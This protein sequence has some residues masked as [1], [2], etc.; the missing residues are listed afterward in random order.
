MDSFVECCEIWFELVLGRGVAD[1]MLRPLIRA[2][3]D[4]IN[5]F[6]KIF[7][8]FT[9]NSGTKEVLLW[10][11]AAG[12]C[13][14]KLIYTY[15][16]LMRS[17]W[18]NGMRYYDNDFFFEFFNDF[19]IIVALYLLP[20]IVKM[21]FNVTPV[22]LIWRSIMNLRPQHAGDVIHVYTNNEDAT[23]A[24]L[25]GNDREVSVCDYMKQ[26]ESDSNVIAER[27]YS[28]AGVYLLTGIVIAIL[29]IAV[30]VAYTKE[31]KQEREFTVVILD[32]LPKFGVMFFVEFIAFYFF[33]QHRVLM[34]EFRFYESIKRQRQ[35]NLVIVKLAN[36]NETL[37]NSVSGHI[38]LFDNPDKMGANETTGLNELRKLSNEELGIFHKILDLTQFIKSEEGKNKAGNNMNS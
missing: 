18:D 16:Y 37:L 35:S 4:V 8:F 2:A 10:W 23:T 11:L 5:I 12:A 3:E 14:I 28:R 9:K 19:L 7:N 13:S 31:M 33:K 34:D 6:S 17:R 25:N 22:L 1:I 30:F 24:T 32:L 20:V 26:L 36:E 38:K 27:T 21:I 15:N 29:G